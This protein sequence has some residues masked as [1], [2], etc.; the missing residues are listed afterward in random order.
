VVRPGPVRVLLYQIS[1]RE[2]DTPV[3]PRYD[4]IIQIWTPFAASESAMTK[5]QNTINPTNRLTSFYPD[6]VIAFPT[7]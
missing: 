1:G 6:E 3:L 7:P 4:N 5:Q 2:Y